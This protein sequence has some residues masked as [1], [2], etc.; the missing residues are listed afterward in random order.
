MSV[1]T[2]GAITMFAGQDSIK[3]AELQAWL[4]KCSLVA[5]MG[6]RS[7]IPVRAMIHAPLLASYDKDPETGRVTWYD[8]LQGKTVMSDA[9][10][11]LVF[12]ASNALDS[13]FSDGTADTV[14][15]LAKLMQLPE[16][17]EINDYGRKLHSDW[18]RTIKACTEEVPKIVA[19]LN[20]KGAGS[21][22]AEVQLGTQINLL[23]QLCSWWDRAPNVMRYEIG[24][25]EKNQLERQIT[26]LQ[27]QLAQMR[28]QRQ[29]TTGR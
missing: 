13:G 19:R 11:N 23:R 8:S 25:P 26:E 6:G 21:G 2:L 16:W 10:D 5:E 14:E 22:D 17:Y 3:G 29:R 4:D 15:Q 18:Q 20:Y 7:P 28:K 1:G 9:K 24:V 27:R 12:N